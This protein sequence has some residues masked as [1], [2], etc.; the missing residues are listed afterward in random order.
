MYK[1]QVEDQVKRWDKDLGLTPKAPDSI[2][3]SMQLSEIR[4]HIAAM[5]ENRVGFVTKH[6]DDPRVVA[7]ILGAPPFLSGLTD[8]EFDVVKAQIAKRTNPAVASAKDETMKALQQCESGWRTAIRQI[9][10]RGG[11]EK[12]H[13]GVAQRAGT[14]MSDV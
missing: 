2:S 6:A 3:E 1:R 4:A 12:S 5:K 10:G 13:D 9:S 11:L 14:S 7:A 8:A